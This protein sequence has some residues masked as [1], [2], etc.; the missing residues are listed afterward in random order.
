MSRTAH[1]SSTRSHHGAH[2]L[3]AL[4]LVGAGFVGGGLAGASGAAVAA[5]DDNADDTA[6]RWS[7]YAIPATGDAAGGW[8]GGYRAGRAELYLT[9]PTRRPNRDGFQ[10]PRPVG[11]LAGQGASP[12]ETARAAWI[13]SKYGAYREA[14]QSAAVDATVYHLLVGGTWRI[15]GRQGARR[16]RQSGNGPAVRRFARI[17][18]RQ[19]RHSAG[20]YA[21]RLSVTG[22]DV[23]GTVAV[24]LS[25]RDGHGRPAAGLPVTLRMAGGDPREAVTGDDGQAV[26]RFPAD[27]RGWQDVTV[28]VGHVPEHRLVVWRPQARHQAA[29]VEGGVTRT[30]VESTRV[31]VRGQQTLSLAADPAQLVVGSAARVVATV[32]GDPVRRTAAAA[33]RGPFATAG[34]GSCAGPTAGQVSAPVTG[35]GTYAL[36]ALSPTAGYFVWQVAVDGTDTNAPVAA[37]GAPVKVRGRATTTIA[38][39]ADVLPVGELGATADVAGLPFADQVTLTATLAGPYAS[40]LAAIHDGCA[41]VV[42]EATRTRVG[43]GSAHVTIAVTQTGWYAWQVQAA[44]GDLWLGSRSGCG[45]VTSMV[46]VQ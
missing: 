45:A 12:G 34:A 18:L 42:G 6:Q 40:P 25:V 2:R 39:D 32:A 10:A 29:A 23:G 36:P 35:D 3:A 22:A 31:A 44:P 5:A 7:G 21:A 24:T 33:L 20:A 16:I 14:T 1:C 26:A 8:I 19:S 27:T 46:G 28:T 30:L 13:L 37:C 41:T 4:L 43:N 17:M 15:D 11:D 9:T 38:T